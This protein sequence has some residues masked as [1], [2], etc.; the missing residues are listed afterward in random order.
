MMAISGFLCWG[1]MTMMNR[2]GIVVG[3]LLGALSMVWSGAAAA[4]SAGSVFRDCAECPEMVVIPPG[5][6]FMGSPKNEASHSLEASHYVFEGPIHRVKI[7]QPFAAGKYEVT[8]AEWDACVSAGGCNGYTPLD[9]GWGRGRRPVINVSWQDAQVYVAWLSGKTG[10][11]YRLLS[12]AEWEYVARAGTTT[13][14]S[15]G[16]TITTDQ[17]NFDGNYTYNGSSKGVDRKK[18]VEVGSFPPNPFGLY[19]VHGNVWE[20]VEDCWHDDYNG[21]PTDGRAWTTEG[22]KYRLLRGGSWYMPPW[23]LRSADRHRYTPDDRDYRYGFRVARTLT[24]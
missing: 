4:Q 22:C 3:I 7:G 8:F 21:A 13:P 24:P 18:T 12:E 5:S 19:D 1:E 15:T 6:F 16:R 10:R 2:L 11:T 9:N 14:F 17:A 20:W 23:A